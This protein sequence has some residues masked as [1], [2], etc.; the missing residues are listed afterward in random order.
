[1]HD[2][3]MGEGCSVVKKKKFENCKIQKKKKKK[4]KK[5]QK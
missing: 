2:L 1:M 3:G 5:N 4:K